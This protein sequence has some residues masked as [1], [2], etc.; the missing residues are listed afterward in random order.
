MRLHCRKQLQTANLVTLGSRDPPKNRSR[1]CL[2]G[3]GDIGQLL[4]GRSLGDKVVDDVAVHIGQ[5]EIAT[6]EAI[7]QLLVV[8]AE[9]MKDRRVD[10]V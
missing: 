3:R 10:V 9:L 7:R 6:G 2:K 4:I 5:A 1:C 8:E